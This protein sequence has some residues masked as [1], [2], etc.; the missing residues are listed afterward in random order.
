MSIFVSEKEIT[1]IKVSI[2]SLIT[3][4][5]QLHFTSFFLIPH[6]PL[7]PP[8]MTPK[9]SSRL[10]VHL[11]VHE[12]VR[13]NASALVLLSSSLLQAAAEPGQC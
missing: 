12:L 7:S 13:T 10:P 9:L 2:C 3:P 1:H 4:W 11:C 8:P 5:K 6:L